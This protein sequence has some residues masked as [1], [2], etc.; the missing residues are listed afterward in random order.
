M[1]DRKIVLMVVM[2]GHVADVPVGKVA[3]ID[4]IVHHDDSH[5]DGGPLVVL[6]PSVRW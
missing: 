3:T 4:I 5:S 1:S 2:F 6:V